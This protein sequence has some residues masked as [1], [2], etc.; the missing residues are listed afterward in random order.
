MDD[1]V[2]VS[3]ANHVTDEWLDSVVGGAR[4]PRNWLF[5]AEGLMRCA[6]E[7][8]AAHER[9]RNR[10][11]RASVEAQ[12]FRSDE[13]VRELHEAIEESLSFGGPA[14]MLRGFAIENLLKGLL[15][16]R[17]PEQWVKRRPTQLFNWTHDLRTL[18]TQVQAHLE[19]AEQ[20][21]VDRLT[22]FIQWGGRYPTAMKAKDH[23]PSGAS[24][25]SDDLPVISALFTRFKALFEQQV[26]LAVTS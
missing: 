18:A 21:V 2:S 13:T 5:R 6:D 9:S 15:V 16:A 14:L 10:W 25:S 23:P 19:P 26:E 1:E 7:L 12:L 11:L 4:N 20:E 17:D 8:E 24:W 3:D 22:L